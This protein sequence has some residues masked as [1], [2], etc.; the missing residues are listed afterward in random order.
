MD[1]L[2]ISGDY[3][4]Y[5]HFLGLIIQKNY[6]F[7]KTD[8]FH[9]SMYFEIKIWP[10]KTLSISWTL[11]KSPRILPFCGNIITPYQ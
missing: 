6:I 3:F 7:G 10:I 11:R 5:G 1:I 2:S 4:Q 8:L 9:G